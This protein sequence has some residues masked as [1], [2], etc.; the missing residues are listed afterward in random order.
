MYIKYFDG[1]KAF[2]SIF[3]GYPTSLVH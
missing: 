2:K 3:T 1:D